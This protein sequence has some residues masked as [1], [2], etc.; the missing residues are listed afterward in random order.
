MNLPYEEPEK[1]I[2]AAEWY[3]LDEVKLLTNVKGEKKY[4]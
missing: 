2:N 3:Q 4:E 1:V